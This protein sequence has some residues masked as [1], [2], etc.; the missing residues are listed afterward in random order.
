MYQYFIKIVPTVYHMLNGEVSA[1]S[2]PH[3]MAHLPHKQ[4]PLVRFDVWILSLV[5]NNDDESSVALWASGWN[6][7]KTDFYERS[8]SWVQVVKFVD[9]KK[10]YF[11]Q[12]NRDFSHDTHD[13]HGASIT[14]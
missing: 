13:A 6:W 10:Q 9:A 12:E 3:N 8:I 2:V 5:H 14:L 1:H 11:D 4:A 7:N